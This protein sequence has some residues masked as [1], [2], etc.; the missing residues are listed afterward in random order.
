MNRYHIPWGR[1]VAQFC[2][3]SLHYNE[4]IKLARGG[5]RLLLRS[6]CTGLCQLSSRFVVSEVNNQALVST[7]EHTYDACPKYSELGSFRIIAYLYVSDS[8]RR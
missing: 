1:R 2:R 3:F 4:V 8:S 5:L 6:Q 7:V